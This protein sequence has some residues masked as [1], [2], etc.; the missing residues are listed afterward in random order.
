MSC[1]SKNSPSLPVFVPIDIF[2]VIDEFIYIKI[3]IK[4][5]SLKFILNRFY[6][7]SFKEEVK[8][9]DEPFEHFDKLNKNNIINQGILYV[10][11]VF[12]L[13]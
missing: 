11:K 3:E 4:I 10:C 1:F 8:R 7:L 2:N 6:V 9:S 13:R 12:C 5:G